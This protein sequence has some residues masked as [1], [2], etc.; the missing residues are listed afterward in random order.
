MATGDD[1]TA[2]V[3]VEV[4][5]FLGLLLFLQFRV[6]QSRLPGVGRRG[7]ATVARAMS[8]KLE[9]PFGRRQLHF[10]TCGCYG[11]RLLSGMVPKRDSSVTLRLNPRPS[12]EAKA[13]RVGHPK[14]QRRSFG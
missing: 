8:N 5:W 6:P 2:V 10:I 4:D 13:R 1:T 12:H 11:R 9:R 7:C 3:D 14:I